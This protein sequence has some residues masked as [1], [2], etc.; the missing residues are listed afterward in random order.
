MYLSSDITDLN[1]YNVAYAVKLLQYRIPHHGRGG[2]KSFGSRIRGESPSSLGRSRSD[3]VL[4][5]VD[6]I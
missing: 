3:E 4:P 6:N 1:K 5:L 2:H